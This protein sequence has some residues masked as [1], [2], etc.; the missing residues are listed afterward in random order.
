MYLMRANLSC[1][2]IK[3]KK[4]LKEM[5]KMKRILSILLT[6][7]MVLGL[8]SGLTLVA[9]A[10]FD[11]TAAGITGQGTESDPYIIDSEAKFTAVF[12][13]TNSD[14]ESYG[15][16]KYYK[17]TENL[18]ITGEH[19][20][21]KMLFQGVLYAD[22]NKTITFSSIPNMQY[23]LNEL[24]SDADMG[25]TDNNKI[26]YATL[27]PAAKG[28]TIKN[29]TLNGT[30]TNS[31]AHIAAAFVAV[32]HS[33]VIENCVNNIDMPC[34]S[35]SVA[36]GG[37]VGLARAGTVLTDCV[38]NG[39]IKGKVV[40]GGIVG[41][42]SSNKTI[43]GC[44]NYGD[45]VSYNGTWAI[46][47]GIVGCQRTYTTI[48]ECAN[49]GDVTCGNGANSYAPGGIIGN[50]T[51]YGTAKT[52]VSECMNVGNIKAELSTAYPAS[53]VG[54]TN[55]NI[56]IDD[57]FN[58]GTVSG[59]AAQGRVIGKVSALASTEGITI[60]RFY[61]ANLSNTGNAM[62]TT[63]SA[64]VIIQNVYALSETPDAE[65][66]ENELTKVSSDTLKSLSLV[67]FSDDKWEIKP[68]NAYGYPTLKAVPYFIAGPESLTASTAVMTSNDG[69]SLTIGETAYNTYVLVAGKA[70]K[71]EGF[72]LKEF[73]VI[74]DSKKF[75]ADSDKIY[76]SAFGCLL[77]NT[78]STVNG[79]KN[80]QEYKVYPYAIYESDYGVEFEVYGNSETFTLNIE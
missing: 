8:S 79:F 3:N 63:T 75:T 1:P 35:V 58:L 29:L 65:A 67:N 51:N 28:A 80:G 46:T 50:I 13:S 7:T 18:T 54:E 47:G 40:A 16:G 59:G 38:N 22:E 57:C 37:F 74:V 2:S 77:Y 60:R 68:D 24:K 73:G 31:N 66:V 23:Y 9:S 70:P 21:N 71:I 52:T 4:F 12:S 33:T 49:Y 14:A 15:V 20:A 72:E 56:Q 53:I 26:A 44:K 45:I 76:E 64:S 61:D 55:V 19:K 42:S 36:V 48:S 10:A 11:Y 34:S 27:F 62:A 39:D 30:M 78:E 6:L 17:I 41:D 32:A 69:D 43:S 5:T 25:I